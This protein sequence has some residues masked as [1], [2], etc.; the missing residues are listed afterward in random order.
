M[1]NVDFANILP[2]WQ[3]LHGC[4]LVARR[5]QW[6]FWLKKNFFFDSF[7]MFEYVATIDLLQHTHS[8]ALER[9]LHYLLGKVRMCKLYTYILYV[10]H[11]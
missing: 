4:G 2:Y 3:D 8:L 1:F 10:Y 5:F 9:V 7:F 6:I 11:F